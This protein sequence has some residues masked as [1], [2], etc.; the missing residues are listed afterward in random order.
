M[1]ECIISKNILAEGNKFFLE[2]ES[3]AL[4]TFLNTHNFKA[5]SIAEQRENKRQQVSFTKG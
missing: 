5:G 4:H 1:L 3:Y 2:D